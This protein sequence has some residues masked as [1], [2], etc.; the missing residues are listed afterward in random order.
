MKLGIVIYSTDSEVVWN[1]FR[2]GVFALTQ[3]RDR[4]RVFLLAGGVECETLDTD[5][6]EVTAQ[7]QA[8]VDAGGVIH[9]C[10]S[11][12]E[13]RRQEKNKRKREQNLINRLQDVLVEYNE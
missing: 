4:V 3:R 12:L 2:L 8:F 9:A 1:A 11:C 13:I 10:G 5:K 7:M 6:F